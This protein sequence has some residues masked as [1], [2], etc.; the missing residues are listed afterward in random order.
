MTVLRACEAKVAVL[1]KAIGAYRRAEHPAIGKMSAERLSAYVQE[2][3]VREYVRQS[4]TEGRPYISTTAW[5][6]AAAAYRRAEHPPT[7]KMGRDALTDYMQTFE[8]R[9][10]GKRKELALRHDVCDGPR[11]R[12]PA[13]VRKYGPAE[14]TFDDEGP[15]AEVKLRPRKARRERAARPKSEYQK[16]VAEKLR[17]KG[18]WNRGYKKRS[19][20]N[21]AY[22]NATQPQ[23][24]QIIAKLWREQ[25]EAKANAE[26][27]EALRREE[28]LAQPR[29]KPV[30]IPKKKKPQSGQGHWW[31]ED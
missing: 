5:R 31:E 23:K 24:M 25:Q 29:Y 28:I 17:D 21:R 20:G 30:K 19:H 2:F 14:P 6:R 15:N 12:V 8:I 27:A 11:R 16:F 3:P 1:R 10:R 9:A 7:G 13:L 18:L 26:H 4:D 22:I